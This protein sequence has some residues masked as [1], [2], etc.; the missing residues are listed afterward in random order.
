M[1]N[2]LLRYPFCFPAF[3]GILLGLLFPFAAI[4]LLLWHQNLSFNWHN[5]AG[6]HSNNLI[7]FIIWTAPLVLGFFGF[8]IGRTGL[9]LRQKMDHLKHQT[10]ELNTILE[11]AA[12]AIIT[13]DTQGNITT[14]NKAAEHIFG[15]APDELL[16]KNVNCLMPSAIAAA[17][18]GYLQRYLETQ[19]GTII[20][21]RREVQ[22]LRKDGTLFPALLRVNP[23]KIDN[24][25]FFSGV[26]DDISDTK[27]LE[28]QLLRAQKLEAIGQLASG[29]AHE[30][31]TPI[32]YIGDNLS[33]LKQNLDDILAYH[34]ATSQLLPDE[35]AAQ[36]S[37]LAE[38]YDLDFILQDSPKA[39]QQSLEGV[40]RVAEIVKAM[41]A[42]SHIGSEKSK[43]AINVHEALSSALTLCR[44][45]CKYIADIETEFSAEI[46]TLECY[47]NQLNQVFVN[48][49]INAAH[50]IE[51][52]QQGKGLIRISTRNIDH[53]LEIQ[54]QD[55]GTGIPEH[56]RDKVFNLFF[57][58]K[59]VGKGTGQGLGLAHSIIVEKHQGKLFFESEVGIGTTFYI[60]LPLKPSL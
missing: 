20:G 2:F 25:I 18:D 5:I 15:Y 9:L 43:Q 34:Q 46:A 38:Q 49:I 39:I 44:N 11:T 42:F 1:I 59:P 32:Q 35:C 23:M 8:V 14:L 22:A 26:I 51:E 45:N 37:Q 50:A 6:L 31:N 41:K 33:A 21:K 19:Q 3:G 16:G 4:S 53:L 29:V 52:K 17:H 13:I 58:T 54:I 55:N 24:M 57:T 12:S 48:L 47:A 28:E 30:I 7:L 56:I 40:Y 10:T 27:I 60:Q 36:F